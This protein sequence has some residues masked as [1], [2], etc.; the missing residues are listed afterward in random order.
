MAVEFWIWL[1]CLLSLFMAIIYI[2]MELAQFSLS[3]LIC[4]EFGS[5]TGKVTSHGKN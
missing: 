4:F 3:L 2:Y 5:R 1:C